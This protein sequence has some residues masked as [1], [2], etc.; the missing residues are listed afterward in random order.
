VLFRSF[1]RS[2]I[3]YI[4]GADKENWLADMKIYLHIGLYAFRRDVLPEVTRLPQSSL[5]KAE[6]LE[7][8]RWLENGY[9]IT[10]KITTYDSFGIDTPE[11]LA[12]L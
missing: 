6:S 8:L 10:V 11:D 12:G 4:R 5:E 3:P 1:S 9:H 2:P 7:Q